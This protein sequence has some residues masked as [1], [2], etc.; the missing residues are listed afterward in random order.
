MYANNLIPTITKPTRPKT[1]TLI[2]NIFTNNHQDNQKQEKGIIYAD[3]SDHLPIYNISKNINIADNTDC[4]VWKRK[5]DRASVQAFINTV[6]GY[7][8]SELLSATDAQIAY[9]LFHN[10]LIECYENHLPVK[11]SKL[12][13]YKARLPWLNDTLKA[14]I[15]QKKKCSVY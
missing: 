2:D 13:K 1:R 4:F 5:K 10:K 11:M 8:W 3:L 15:K 6:I 9:D 12:N 14:S 7:N